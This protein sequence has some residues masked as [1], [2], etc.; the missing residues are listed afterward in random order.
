MASEAVVIETLVMFQNTLVVPN[1]IDLRSD[2]M[3]DLWCAFAKDVPD[4]NLRAA[5]IEYCRRSKFYE[6]WPMMEQILTGGDEAVELAWMRVREALRERGSYG[7]LAHMKA[8]DK[9]AY[10]A[11]SHMENVET[12][13]HIVQPPNFEE[14]KRQEFMRI[15]KTARR[16]NLTDPRSELPAPGAPALPDRS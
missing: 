16:Y 11:L 14:R 6:G 3:I 4:A 5:A 1:N 10:F 7:A 9:Y 13:N 2:H 15:Y 8:T 12:L